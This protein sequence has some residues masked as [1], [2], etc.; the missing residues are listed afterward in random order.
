MAGYLYYVFFIVQ[1]PI[2]LA[3]LKILLKEVVVLLKEVVVLSSSVF[4]LLSR[5]YD[6]SPHEKDMSSM[7]V[8]FKANKS[9]V[10]GYFH[11]RLG[12]MQEND[13]D[14]LILQSFAY[15]WTWMQK[16][17]NLSDDFARGHL[18][19]LCRDVLLNYWKAEGRTSARIVVCCIEDGKMVDHELFLKDDEYL[20]N[21]AIIET[22]KVAFSGLTNPQQDAIKHVEYG[23]EPLKDFAKRNC[24]S[25]Q[26]VQ[27][28]VKQAKV[29]LKHLL[30]RDL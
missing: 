10:R 22:V 21:A 17:P 2:L 14:D 20:K 6:F 8:V 11:K 28:R 26:A 7:D 30:D 12:K 24:I 18:F 15:L 5:G 4:L 13:I 29:S 23:G 1:V 27:A 16:N 19:T 25:Y 9:W 3:S